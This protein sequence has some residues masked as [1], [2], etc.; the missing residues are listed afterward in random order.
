LLPGDL[1]YSLCADFITD[2]LGRVLASVCGG[3]LV[4]IQF[5]IE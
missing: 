3:D 2:D 5:L 4:G 1:Q